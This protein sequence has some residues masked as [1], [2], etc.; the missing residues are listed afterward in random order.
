[1]L[2]DEYCFSFGQE[3]FFMKLEAITTEPQDRAVCWE[4]VLSAWSHTGHLYSY[5]QGSKTIAEDE[6]G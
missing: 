5:L 6:A 2:T 1:M 3:W 4:Q